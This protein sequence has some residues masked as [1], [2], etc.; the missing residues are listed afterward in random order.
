MAP[1]SALGLDDGLDDGLCMLLGGG[2][3]RCTTTS[4]SLRI[5]HVA[6]EIAGRADTR[7]VKVAASSYRYRMQRCNRCTPHASS[8][9]RRA[10]LT[11]LVRSVAQR[12]H[13]AEHIVFTI[14]TMAQMTRYTWH[15]GMLR[16]GR[17]TYQC[18][19]SSTW[20]AHGARWTH[21]K[22]GGRSQRGFIPDTVLN[23]R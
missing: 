3:A 8:D 16:G 4:D 7:D 11:P 23:R 17:L 20:Y 9:V 2:T 13:R 12:E 19:S 21:R 10:Y 5:A 14:D 15:P 1:L 18:L 22:S 6:I